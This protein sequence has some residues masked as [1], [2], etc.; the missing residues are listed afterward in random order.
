MFRAL[1][2][3]E[4]TIA[5]ENVGTYWEGMPKAEAIL[6]LTMYEAAPSAI[7]FLGLFS[8]PVDINF[9]SERVWPIPRMPEVK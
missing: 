1:K 6:S 9:E 4:L 3:Q 8:G 2:G 5:L 7:D